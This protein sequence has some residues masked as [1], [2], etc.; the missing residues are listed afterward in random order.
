M[1]ALEAMRAPRPGRP[2]SSPNEM[3]LA[4]KAVQMQTAGV[5]DFEPD[6]V[7]K[8][9]ELRIFCGYTQREVAQLSKVGEKTLSSFE[10]G[11]RIGCLKLAH[12][13][14]ILTVYGLTEKEFFADEFEDVLFAAGGS[15]DRRSVTWFAAQ[16]IRLIHA[17][18]RYGH[19][20]SGLISKVV[21][22]LAER[23]VV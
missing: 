4:A 5:S 19:H 12:L 10:T 21:E 17:A 2:R 16:I 3:S 15:Q 18:Q 14:R 23:R 13:H 11:Q 22:I 7:I 1:N 9:R 8:L 6:I 20:P